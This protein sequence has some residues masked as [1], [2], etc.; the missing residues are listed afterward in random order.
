MKRTWLL[1]KLIFLIFFTPNVYSQAWKQY[2]DSAKTNAEK[3]LPGVAIAWYKKAQAQLPN[4][5]IYTQ[6]NILLHRSLASLY[7]S[8]KQY[9]DAIS[10]GKDLMQLVDRILPEKNG[11]YAWACNLLGVI[12][13]MNGVEDSAKVFHLKAK[14]IREKLFGNKDPAYAQS[15]NNLGALYRDMGEYNLAEPLLLEAKEIREKLPLAKQNDPFAITCVGLGNLYRD[16]GQYEKAEGYY[17]FA[18]NRRALSGKENWEYASSCN[19]LADLYAYMQQFEKAETLY[20]EAKTIRAGL[21]IEST[22]YAQ[23]CNNLS[24]L[25]KDMGLYKKALSLAFEAKR[26]YDSLPAGH[27]SRAI[28]FNTLGTVYFA[29]KDYPKAKFNFLQARKLWL[30]QLGKDHVYIAQNAANLARVFWNLNNLAKAN[31]FYEAAFIGHYNQIKKTFQFTNEKEK[32]LYLQNATGSV[33]EY[34][35]FYYQKFRS[36]NVPQPYTIAIANRELILYSTQQVRQ[37]I[38]NSGDTF[39]IKKYKEWVLLKEKIALL[40]SRQNIGNPVEIKEVEDKADVIEKELS[41]RSLAFKS[42]QKKITWQNIQ[43]SLKKG[44]AAVE[45]VEFQYYD[46]SHWTDSTF[47]VALLLRKEK[48]GA[49]MI[50]LFEK[51]Q[52]NNLLQQV[53]ANE[54]INQ[55]YT[56]KTGNQLYG[57][58]WKPLEKYLN[59]VTKVFFAPAGNLFKISLAAL[60]T[61]N[62][63]LLSDQYELVQLNTT[64]SIVNTQPSLLTA[65]DHLQLYGGIIYDVESNDTGPIIP[66]K[67]SANNTNSQAS[68]AAT[69]GGSFQYLP[70]TKNEVAAIKKQAD[71]SHFPA[72]VLSGINAKEETIKAL[73]GN[74]SPSVLHIATHGFFFQDPKYDTRDSIEKKLEKSGKVFRQSENP[75]LR[76]GLLFAGANKAWQGKSFTGADDGILTA[77]EVSNMYLPHTKLVVLSACETALGTVEG[78][79]GV[80]GLQRGFKMAGVKNLVM[81]LWKVPDAEAS[82]FM[83]LFFANMFNKQPITDAFYKAQAAMKNKYRSDTYKWAAWILIN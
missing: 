73:S 44:E 13:N 57:L 55:F 69:R 48:P 80:Y 74:N 53:N 42:L 78:S 19:I 12:Y 6:T 16:M 64:A 9:K 2:C 81:S 21:D 63:K 38:N 27:P 70:G 35:S 51:S 14:T 46:G 39:L 4:D 29:M 67:E 45:F 76:S 10:T 52:L 17:L 58:I 26:I 7:Y 11:D 59:G 79:E 49:Q 50:P 15:C 56:G 40:L 47:Y 23:S 37:N 72:L 1:L 31:E 5:S 32:N 68:V 24:S 20:L 77:Y 34:Q 18:K 30:S 28:G 82:E 3:Q 61:N 22:D 66:G 33:D 25:Y 43:Q 36:K 60:P 65:S 83:Q 62:K 54:N 8:T 71:E 41:L 75:L